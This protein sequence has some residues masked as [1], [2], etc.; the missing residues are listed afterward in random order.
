MLVKD[1]IRTSFV[2]L[3]YH[4]WQEILGAFSTSTL[5]LVIGSVAIPTLIWLG[6]VAVQF[7]LLRRRKVRS[8]L[9]EAFAQS[10][11]SA[12]VTATMT[13]IAWTVIVGCFLVKIVYDDHQSLVNRLQ[14][15]QGY[16]KNKQQFDNQL[17]DARSEAE[18]WRGAYLAQSHGDIHPDRVLNAEQTNTLFQELKRI[19]NDPKN[20]DFVKVEIGCVLGD[21]EACHLANQLFKT[22]NEAHWK[23]TWKRKL[24][25][26][27]DNPNYASVRGVTIWTDDDRNKGMFLMWELKDA[28]LSESYVN[29]FP[30]PPN[31]K[32]TVVW[33][34]YKQ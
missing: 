17:R 10:W 30:I 34:G 18:R 32:G 21:R 16:A 24:A 19:S 31:F 14:D 3:L 12:V 27:F 23:V 8:P 4:T 7:W 13:V 5:S 20:K 2:N 15:L 33:V 26:E 28:G 29:P 6:N 11:V 25:K 22:L 1:P 9:R